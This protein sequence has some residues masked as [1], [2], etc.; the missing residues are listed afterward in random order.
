VKSGDVRTTFSLLFIS[1]LFSATV[2]S[3]QPILL[4]TD[5]DDHTLHAIDIE[6]G[7]TQKVGWLGDSGIMAGLAYDPTTDT[8]YG[9]AYG[10]TPDRDNLYWIDYTT[11]R[12]N[13]L[14]SLGVTQMHGLACDPSSGALYGTY[15]GPEGD[16]LYRINRT[17]GQA[18]LI[19]NIGFFGSP[20]NRVYGLAIDPDTNTLYGAVGYAASYW[21]GLVKINKSTGEG[22]LVAEMSQHIVGLAFHPDTGVLYGVNNHNTNL[23]S[24]DTTTGATTLICST[25]L[26]NGLGLAFVDAAGTFNHRPVAHDDAAHTSENTS[27][28][29]DVLDNDSDP[30]SDPLT[31]SAVTQGSNGSTLIVGDAVMYTPDTD[32]TG[33]DLFAY[34]V[35]DGRGGS[36]SATVTVNVIGGVVNNPP[37]VDAGADIDLA[38][39]GPVPLTIPLVGSARDTDQGPEP[40]TAEWTQVDG[41][42]GLEFV[43]QNSVSSAVILY[44]LGNYRLRLAASDGAATS[45]DDIEVEVRDA[46]KDNL[47]AYWAFEQTGMGAL[48]DSSGNGHHGTVTGEVWLVP[49][50]AGLSTALYNSGQP[51]E[52]ISVPHHPDFNIANHITIAAWL[53]PDQTVADIGRGTIVAKGAAG[54]CLFSI[55]PEDGHAQIGFS[56][57]SGQ[58]IIADGN[59]LNGSELPVTNYHLPTWYHTVGTYDGRKMRLYV[60]G[61]LTACE[62]YGGGIA[63]NTASLTIGASTIPWDNGFVGCIDEIRIYNEALTPS[64]ILALYYG[65][66]QAIAFEQSLIPGDVNRDGCVNFSDLAI[67]GSNWL[68]GD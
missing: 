18:S 29:I 49:S 39:S 37:L 61:R 20:Y 66:S 25:G 24:I 11:G 41:P 1:L 13:W 33:S 22:T 14:G 67:I 43:E 15:G 68:R 64:Q 50:A 3:A 63:T 28:T 35:T 7:K 40:L 30:D 10:S 31:I 65:S 60:N 27:V 46:G 47:V 55:V 2:V 26:G 58:Y 59:C 17:T 8:L 34:T 38:F 5:T 51:D 23:Y 53:S 56:V 19:G 9:S 48:A 4:V 45:S 57:A 62:D 6:T 54:W 32:F 12:A 36:D 42:E 52:Y 44:S 16:G 21:G